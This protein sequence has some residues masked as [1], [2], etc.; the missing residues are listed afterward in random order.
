VP[1]AGSDLQTEQLPASPRPLA[2]VVTEQTAV[3]APPW[4][5]AFD[6]R[7]ED[8]RSV[9]VRPT[10]HNPTT[11]PRRAKQVAFIT[12]GVVALIVVAVV[13]SIGLTGTPGSTT[14][15]VATGPK[16]LPAGAVLAAESATDAPVPTAAGLAAALAKPL[17]DARLGTHVSFAVTDLATGKVLYGKG[18]TS[19]TIPASSMKLATATAALALRGPNYRITTE[20][21]AGPHPGEVV[22]VGAGDPTLG[23]Q[24]TTTYPE[25]GRLDVLADQAKRALGGT[26]PTKV[27][28]DTSL[29]P[30]SPIGPDWLLEDVNGPYVARIYP[31]ST[32]GGRVN[33]RNLG[34]AKR[35]PNSAVAA[36]D[37]FAKYL[38][39][40]ATAV[41]AGE[42][43]AAP[44]ATSSPITPGA[45]LGKVQ[46]APL[47]RI[48]ETMLTTSDNV[49]AEFVARQ[50]ALASGKPASFA[51]AA[52][53][54]ADE[55]RTLGMPMTNV[56]IVDG[57]GLSTDNRLT[58]ALLTAILGYDAQPAHTAF[59]SL[60]G[61]MPV[62]GYSGT[63]QNRFDKVGTTD[64][65]GALRA[66]TGTLTGVSALAGVV[67]DSSG[68]PLAFAL[69]MDKVAV[70]ANVGLAADVVGETLY[71]CGCG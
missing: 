59:H 43:P 30:G 22:L 44:A 6:H 25:S 60:F 42:A 52:E 5:E 12:A 56:K 68:R 23:A 3:I 32:D 28:Y 62:A 36:A 38:G 4:M 35:F 21:V 14:P 10:P 40:P 69:M 9:D 47:G 20:V 67:I 33:P 58:P 65:R 66:K 18:A 53:A 31:L 2:G 57:S 34:A 71:R 54:V 46:S 27:I 50:V 26:T 19:P 45:V 64:A 49:L 7:P 37:F 1:K 70:N 41:V 63:L 61:G 8:H 39:V 24:A 55:L 16:V 51:G 29:F 17:K 15:P 13:A 48:I 11:N